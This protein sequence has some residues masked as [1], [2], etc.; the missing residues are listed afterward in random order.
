MD[1]KFHSADLQRGHPFDTTRFQNSTDIT[2]RGVLQGIYQVPHP[3]SHSGQTVPDKNT[4]RELLTYEMK[5]LPF[6]IFP[7]N[8]VRHKKQ[9]QLIKL[10]KKFQERKWE[11]LCQAEYFHQHG[12]ISRTAQV[13]T[14][15]SKPTSHPDHYKRLQ[16]LFRPLQ[17]GEDLSQHRPSEIEINGSWDTQQAFERIVKCHSE[18]SYFIKN[19]FQRIFQI[20]KISQG[21]RSRLLVYTVVKGRFP[22]TKFRVGVSVSLFQLTSG[23]GS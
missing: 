8:R 6:F 19:L 9:N 23:D 11:E 12:E 3:N 4:V 16:H 5:Q 1:S 2:K 20:M 14:N 13:F 18:S 15:G 17:M 21:I 22:L 7:P 10:A